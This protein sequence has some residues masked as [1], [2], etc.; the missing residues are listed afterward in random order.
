MATMQLKAKLSCL[1]VC[2]HTAH[3]S[4]VIL[5]LILLI[6][7]S[8]IDTESPVTMPYNKQKQTNKQT[9]HQTSRS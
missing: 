7:T 6:D 5:L 9:N 1:S 4:S 8:A 2:D 3:R